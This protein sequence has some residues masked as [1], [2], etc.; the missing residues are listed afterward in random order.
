MRLKAIMNNIVK[1]NDIHVCLKQTNQLH[2]KDKFN[3]HVLVN[4]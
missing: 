2:F 3:T 4:N 1:T